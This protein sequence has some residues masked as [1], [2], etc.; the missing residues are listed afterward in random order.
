MVWVSKPSEEGLLVWLSKLG[1]DDLVVCASKP[2]VVGLTGLDLK[3]SEWWIDGHV[4]DL[5]ACI[6]R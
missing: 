6:E 3:I 1:I 2:L 5:E 4:V